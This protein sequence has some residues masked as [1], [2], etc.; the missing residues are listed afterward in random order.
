VA[1]APRF[2][3]SV[4]DDSGALWTADTRVTA[5]DGYAVAALARRAA[6]DGLPTRVNL[7]N[8]GLPF[9]VVPR[10]WLVCLTVEEPRLWGFS[11]PSRS[12]L[13]RVVLPRHRRGPH[14]TRPTSAPTPEQPP[15]DDGPAALGE[16][17]QKWEW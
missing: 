3:T 11:V 1:A 9:V 12:Y 10:R 8:R 14:A 7:S 6:A 15:A 2:R 13:L 16:E 17:F 5:L 4:R